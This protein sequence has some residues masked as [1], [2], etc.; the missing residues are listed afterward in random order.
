MELRFW[1]KDKEDPCLSFLAP[2]S[3]ASHHAIFFAPQINLENMI[4]TCTPRNILCASASFF[5]I[6]FSHLLPFIL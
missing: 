1:I 4:H 2:R 3:G 6:F 5:V